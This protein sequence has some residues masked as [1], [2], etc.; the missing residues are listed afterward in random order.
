MPQIG[1]DAQRALESYS[2]PGNIRELENVIHFALLV[3][4][5]EEI[6]PEHLNFSDAAPGTTLGEIERLVRQLGESQ[7]EEVRALLERLA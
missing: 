5:G 4:P 7:L 3:S 6:L 2:W 1:V